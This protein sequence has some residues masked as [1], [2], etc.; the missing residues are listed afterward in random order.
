MF[1][2]PPAACPHGHSS[3]S[4]AT[5]GDFFTRVTPDRDLRSNQPPGLRRCVRLPFAVS[6]VGGGAVGGARPPSRGSGA[7]HALPAAKW[8]PPP[9][10][11]LPP[12]PPPPVSLAAH[13]ALA[14]AVL[15]E[16]KRFGDKLRVRENK[17]CTE[18]G[19][20][21]T[22]N[23]KGDKTHRGER[24]KSASRSKWCQG[25][26]KV[27]CEWGPAAFYS[28]E[29]SRST[30]LPEI[31]IFL[32]N[33][34]RRLNLKTVRGNFKSTKANLCLMGRRRTVSLSVG[35]VTARCIAVLLQSLQMSG[36]RE[37]AAPPHFPAKLHFFEISHTTCLPLAEFQLEIFLKIVQPGPEP[38]R[39]ETLVLAHANITHSHFVPSKHRNLCK[40]ECLCTLRH[41]F[42]KE[43]EM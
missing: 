22:G 4:P 36:C 15:R 40:L 29:T 27:G 26:L 39:G 12:Q 1:A 37:R 18:S 13:P 28:P 30:P 17:G 10:Q 3:R 7:R 32:E 23:K 19:R 5:P 25:A 34:V 43:P 2:A 38:V 21:G 35:F 16:N 6:P 31:D 20:K 24:D 8:P 42:G 33:F 9:P 11:P 14:G 41:E